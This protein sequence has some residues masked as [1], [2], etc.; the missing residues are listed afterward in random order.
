MNRWRFV[1]HPVCFTASPLNQSNS[2]LDRNVRTQ[3]TGVK[4][5]DDRLYISLLSSFSGNPLSARL[6]AEPRVSRPGARF[7]EPRITRFD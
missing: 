1:L 3:R 4:A 6:P 2:I 5:L 7:V